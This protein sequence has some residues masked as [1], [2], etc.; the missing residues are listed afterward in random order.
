MEMRRDDEARAIW[1]AVY[2]ELSEGKPGMLGAITARAEAQVMRLALIYGLLDMSTVIGAAHLRAALAVWEYAEASAEFIFGSRMGD[3]VA[4][5][6]LDALRRNPDGL[7]RTDIRDLLGRNHSHERIDTAL[8]ALNR[9][10]TARMV[11]E[12]TRGRP[13]ERWIATAR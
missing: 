4:D 7:T 12:T 13:A 6:I 10:G 2:S 9:A 8:A 1:H 5:T 11:R 3:P